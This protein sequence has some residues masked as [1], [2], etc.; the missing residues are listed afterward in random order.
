MTLN[1]VV[2]NATIK[3]RLDIIGPQDM[4]KDILLDFGILHNTM[5]EVLNESLNIG[6][7]ATE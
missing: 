3:E 7:V 4:V 5:L 1:E 2:K 6:D